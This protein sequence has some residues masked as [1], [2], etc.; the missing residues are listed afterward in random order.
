[1]PRVAFA[2][3]AVEVPDGWADIT[4]VVEAKN[5]PYTL[6][7]RNGLGALQFSTALYKSGPIPNPSLADLQEMIAEFSH[8]HVL[9]EPTDV[10]ADPGPPAMVA[11][12]FAWGD[13]FLRVWQVS[14]GRNFARVT[15]TCAAEHAGPELAACEEIVRSIA[16]REGSS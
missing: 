16:F 6:A 15:Y 7:H 14:D 5:P 1:M 2:T 3:F 9:G 8:T 13:D 4:Q 12:S 11:A 10:V